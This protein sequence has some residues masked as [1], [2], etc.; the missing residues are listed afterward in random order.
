MSV[1]VKY[2]IHIHM[3]VVW[4]LSIAISYWFPFERMTQ[5]NLQWALIST[6]Y[7]LFSSEFTLSL[8]R[9][10]TNL[11]SLLRLL[12]STLPIL[13]SLRKTSHQM[14]N[15]SLSYHQVYQSPC[16]YT[17]LICLLSC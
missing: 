5:R 14:S 8:Q 15:P 4:K 10:F 2:K 16:I 9:L 12:P 7:A 3:P 6:C 11:I 17:H 1:L 13:N